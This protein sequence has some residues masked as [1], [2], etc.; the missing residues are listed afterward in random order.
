MDLLSGI[1]RRITVDR[2]AA[3]DPA[4]YLLGLGD[5]GAL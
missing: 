5:L 4:A 2:L 1:Q 3:L